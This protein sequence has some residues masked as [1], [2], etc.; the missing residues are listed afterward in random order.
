MFAAR[1]NFPNI[2]TRLLQQGADVSATD[3]FGRTAKDFACSKN[4]KM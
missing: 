2:V 4:L 3:V 1:N